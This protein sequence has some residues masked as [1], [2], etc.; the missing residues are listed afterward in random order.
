MWSFFRRQT[1]YFL[2]GFAIALVICVA[3]DVGV[4]QLVKY[5][6]ISAI[7]GAVLSIGIFFLER[8]FPD[9]TPTPD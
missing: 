6:I 4:D 5:A 3:Y 8:R 9:R 7:V 1:Y 2:W